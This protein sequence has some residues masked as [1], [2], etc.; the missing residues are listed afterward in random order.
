MGSIY[1][2]GNIYWIKYYRAGK[3]HRESAE[4]EKENDA[5]N[6]LKLRE[7]EIIQGRF[8]GLRVNKI[9]FEELREDLVTDY[10]VNGK[11]Y[12][13]RLERS[14]K[15]LDKFFAGCRIVGITTDRIKVYILQ[16]QEE[17]AEN[18]TINRELAAPQEDVEPCPAND[19]SQG[20]QYALCPPRILRAKTAAFLT[21]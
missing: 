15:H 19:S 20:N 18:A 8:P 10:S 12:L 9:K 3:P 13:P 2:R 5:I 6:L 16:R 17:G 4:S 7:G 21:P 1:K 14:L 11:R